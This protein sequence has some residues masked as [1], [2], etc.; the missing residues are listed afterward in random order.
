MNGI[1]RTISTC[2]VTLL[3]SGFVAAAADV[4]VSVNISGDI[5][6]LADILE[7]LKEVGIG[8]AAVR[9]PRVPLS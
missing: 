3:L 4:T 2:F 1:K 8:Q 7:K 9:S 6:E 5:D